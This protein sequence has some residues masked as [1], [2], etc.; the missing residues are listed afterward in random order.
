[1]SNCIYLIKSGLV[2][3]SH[4]SKLEGAFSLLLHVLPVV[5]VDV[6]AW[7]SILPVRLVVDVVVGVVCPKSF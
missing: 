3:K 7:L 2:C 4:P 1:M 6:V 5:V